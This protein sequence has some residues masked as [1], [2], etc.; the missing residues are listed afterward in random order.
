EVTAD[1]EGGSALS[2][3]LEKFPLIIP[4]IMVHL[5]RAGEAGG[6]LDR[7]LLMVADNFE[8]ETKLRSKVKSAMTYPV[9]V[10]IVALVAVAA[11]LIFIVPVFESMFADLGSALPGP[12]QVLVDLSDAMPIIAPILIVSIV[13]FSIWWGR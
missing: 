13:A 3:S 11:M 10:L 4:P 1:V 12:T 8:A 7:S 9:V 5:I 2:V 6:F